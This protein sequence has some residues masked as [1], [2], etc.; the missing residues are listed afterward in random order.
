MLLEAAVEFDTIAIADA[1]ASEN[2]QGRADGKIDSTLADLGDLFQIFQ[3]SSPAGIGRREWGMV[4]EEGDQFEVRSCLFSFDLD[5]M[6][7]ELGAVGLELLEEERGEDEVGG[8][9][10]FSCGD[11]V[12]LIHFPAA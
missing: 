8:L 6:D 11:E 2:I 5:S 10:P 4:G 1:G 3:G 9:L 7:E 12:F